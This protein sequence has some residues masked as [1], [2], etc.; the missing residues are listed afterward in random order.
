M[1]IETM[2]V[3]NYKALQDVRLVD[4]P[5]YCVFVGVNGSGKSTLF[6]VLGFLRDSLTNNVRQALQVRGGF[7]EV[8]S[9]GHGDEAI[10]IELQFRML[11]AGV[12]RLVTYILSIVQDIGKPI[13]KREILRY[14]RGRYGSP[15]HFLDFSY[16]SG[17]SIHQ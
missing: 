9:R 10:Q 14:K 13:I 15:Y 5:Q 6:N 12:E 7:R 4:L 3:K 2:H 11:I 1:R 8:V 17:Y 16:G